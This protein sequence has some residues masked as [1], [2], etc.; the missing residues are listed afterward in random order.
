MSDALDDPSSKK[1]L[2]VNLLSDLKKE[3]REANISDSVSNKS[4]CLSKYLTF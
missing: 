3:V 2:C 4:Y 1:L